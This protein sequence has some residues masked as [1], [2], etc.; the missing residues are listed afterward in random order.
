MNESES[1]NISSTRGE[2]GLA[3][4]LSRVKIQAEQYDL[5]LA[6]AAVVI[7][8]A[9]AIRVV[10]EGI[11]LWRMIVPLSLMA[12]YVGF[13]VTRSKYSTTR[14]A[15]SVYF[16]GFW[17]T[18]WALISALLWHGEKSP[19]TAAKLYE[20]FG[21]ALVTTA[22]GMF[23]RLMMLQFYRSSIDQEEQAVDQIDQRVSKLVAELELSQQ[24]AASLR[25]SGAL[26]LEQWHQQFL[27]ASDK[28]VADVRRMA[29]SLT[30]E[31]EALSSSLKFVHKSLTS[32]GRGFGT[33]E[34][35]LAEVR[36]DLIQA[37]IDQMLDSVRK[38]A[39]SFQEASV[40]T[41]AQLSKIVEGVA[42]AVADLPNSE[43]IQRAAMELVK[44]LILLGETCSRLTVEAEA[45]GSALS[46][47]QGSAATIGTQLTGASQK[48]TDVQT[49][50]NT[51][52]GTVQAVANNTKK[53]DEAVREVVHF[54]QSTLTERP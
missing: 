24:A 53:V 5:G 33:V 51:L 48:A 49:G 36:P 52:S 18:L 39:A 38:A 34:K 54:V 42:R 8:G 28:I 27:D 4:K 29:A 50:L 37:S 22:A 13:A 17:W 45:T 32:M 40:N 15:D 31:G 35:K 20:T 30:S 7:L 14:V 23:V 2:S 44:K 47:I 3:A 41:L 26:A 46:S 19:L 9:V 25:A 16:M 21:Y 10:P 12:L 11:G 6:W 43:H 1:H